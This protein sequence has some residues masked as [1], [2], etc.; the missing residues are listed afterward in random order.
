VAK[1]SPEA[2]K[3]RL[4]ERKRVDDYYKSKSKEGQMARQASSNRQA[5]RSPPMT[6]DKRSGWDRM[7]DALDQSKK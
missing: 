6:A 5:K 7:K 4:A 1:E 3:K 2:M